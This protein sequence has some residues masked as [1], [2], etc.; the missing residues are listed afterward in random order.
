[1]L[2]SVDEALKGTVGGGQDKAHERTD[3]GFAI[4]S[5]ADLHEKAAAKQP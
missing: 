1:M 4:G 3:E 5:G 2:D